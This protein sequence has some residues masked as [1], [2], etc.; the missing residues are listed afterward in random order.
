MNSGDRGHV[1][2]VNGIPCAGKSSV[3]AEVARKTSTFK[4]LT[5]DEVIRRIPYEQRAAQASHLFE[6]TL[7]MIERWQRS[8]NVI[9]DGAWTERQVLDAQERFGS[10]AFFVILRI[11]EPERRRRESFRR[12]RVLGHPWDPS[13]HD[14]PG[15]DELYDLVIDSRTTTAKESAGLILRA[16]KERWPDIDP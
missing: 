5:G 1:I 12:D 2:H 9:A 14:M 16:A 13:W 6:L 3:A 10:A 8:G 15:P 7:S 11:D 4:I